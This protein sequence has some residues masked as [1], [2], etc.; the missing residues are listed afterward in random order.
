MC[1]LIFSYITFEDAYPHLKHL[2]YNTMNFSESTT[3]FLGLQVQYITYYFDIGNT[4]KASNLSHPEQISNYS[5]L[6]VSFM[7]TNQQKMKTYKDIEA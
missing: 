1:S 6:N 2:P 4:N 3:Y 7:D 5:N